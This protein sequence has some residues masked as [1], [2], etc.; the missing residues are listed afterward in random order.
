MSGAEEEALGDLRANVDRALDEAAMALKDRFMAEVG[1][2]ASSPAATIAK[3]EGYAKKAARLKLRAVRARDDRERATAEEALDS[4]LRTVKTIARAEAVVRSDEAAA[5]LLAGLK[6]ALDVLEDVA[7]GILSAVGAAAVQGV[8]SGLA[9]GGS[10][11]GMTFR[12]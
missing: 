6:A 5:L 10:S 4:V 8:L 7:V 1:R 2:I 11:E 9:G 12:L 3:L